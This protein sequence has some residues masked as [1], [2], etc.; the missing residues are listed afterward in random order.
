MLRYEGFTVLGGE[1]VRK[2]TVS[3]KTTAARYSKA[4][5]M[6]EGRRKGG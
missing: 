6:E 2:S 5:V 3:Q 1:G 4:Y